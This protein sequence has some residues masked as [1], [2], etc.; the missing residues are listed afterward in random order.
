MA[1]RFWIGTRQPSSQVETVTFTGLGGSNETV[2]FTAGTK[3]ITYTKVSGE[4]TTTLATAIADAFV[5][6]SFPELRELTATSSGAVLTL[7]GPSDGSPVTLTIT[8]SGGGSPITW[9]RSTTAAKS[10]NHASDAANYDGGSLPSASDEIVY[11]AGTPD[12]KY[13]LTQFAATA[14]TLTRLVNGPRIGLPNTNE[15]GGYLEYRPRRLQTTA[16]ASRIETSGADQP[17]SVRLEFNG[18]SA[19]TVTILGDTDPGVGG[20]TVELWDLPNNSV[21]NVNGSGVRVLDEDSVAA[22]G[23]TVNAQNSSIA[24]A[25]RATLAAAKLYN[26][27]ANIRGEIT[28]QLLLEAGSRLEFHGSVNTSTGS[29]VVDN[30]QL[31]WISA[32][33]VVNLEIGSDGIVTL[34]N[35][36]GATA[37]TGSIKLYED[38]QL[39]DPN[40]RLTVPYNIDLVR[41][42]LSETIDIGTNR[43]ITVDAIS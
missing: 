14:V 2:T 27:N 19:A 31:G 25:S 13:G 24:A 7:T 15:S 40:S 42:A 43:R 26:A 30:G 34:A 1:R 28:G 37:V 12:V 29:V 4:T 38:G 21:V 17:A 5:A 41:G 16:T 23:I 22:T 9:T 39:L 35:G 20:E 11:A 10:P 36:V 32:S 33:N 8:D 18:A 6:T 3:S